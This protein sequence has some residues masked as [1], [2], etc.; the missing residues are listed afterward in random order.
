MMYDYK[1]HLIIRTPRACPWEQSD[2]NELSFFVYPEFRIYK[3]FK[4]MNGVYYQNMSV[5]Y[6]ERDVYFIQGDFNK[7]LINLFKWSPDCD[8]VELITSIDI[9]E[10]SLYN[11]RIHTSPV[12]ICA[13]DIEKDTVEIYYPERISF[14]LNG[15]ES[16]CYRDGER[17]Y[18]SSWHEEGYDINGNREGE[19]KYWEEYV[20]RDREGNL[21]KKDKGCMTMMPDG[22]ILIL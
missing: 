11:L 7:N 19:Y 6:Y 15:K 18:F 4:R 17:F 3:P 20:V 1:L 21:I 8:F 16:F 22:Q 2:G 10:I 14:H 12:L 9:N 13:E 5:V